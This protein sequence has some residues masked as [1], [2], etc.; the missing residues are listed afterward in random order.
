MII[1]HFRK[2]ILLLS[3]FV[4]L[5][6]QSCAKDDAVDDGKEEVPQETRLV[7]NFV[8][9][10]GQTY[11]LW[12]D[13]IDYSSKD[14]RYIEDPFALFDECIYSELDIWSYLTD[15]AESMFSSYQGVETT[16]G[17]NI[18]LGAFS[19]SESYFA[20]VKFVYAGSPAA[21]AGIKRGDI[22]LKIDGADISESNYLNLYYSSR[23]ELQMGE[24]SSA[25]NAIALSDRKV[26]MT[27]VELSIDAV[28]AYT[29]IEEGT[30]KI[31][32]ICYTDYVTSSHSK[33]AQIFSEFKTA[34]VTDLVLDL[35]YNP[36][37]AS[38]SAQYLSSL[39]VPKK[40]IQNGDIFL[41]ELWNSEMTGY[42][43]SQGEKLYTE[44]SKDALPYNLG[45]DRVYILTT[46]G[47]ASAS[48][49][50]I[51]GLQ[52]Y[53]DVVTIGTTTHGKYCAALL[54]Q[55]VDKNGNV[56][57]SL[58]DWAMSLVVY[59]FANSKGFTDFT[60]GLD[61]LYE[62]E[63]DLITAVYPFGDRRDAHLA[64]AIELITGTKSSAAVSAVAASQSR[65]DYSI[66]EK[67]TRQLDGRRGGYVQF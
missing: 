28:N 52:P 54:L 46:S 27:A 59:K 30:H 48:E 24:Y 17:Y 62:V 20:V 31:G 35:R 41:K 42:L 49:A 21:K 65:A 32:Y 34:G 16:Y 25:D 40:H 11:Y 3:C 14:P 47:T 56:M 60:G 15:D 58:K 8:L 50:T 9:S 33:L 45:L 1:V 57:Q 51:V 2:Y 55:A 39:L 6:F 38:V 29:V 18:A 12:S 67:E 7:N 63:D 43:E 26:S 61:P 36:G 66:L 23:V 53:M 44:F 19:N 37:G 64:K 5:L 22:I 13:K 4:S 10:Y